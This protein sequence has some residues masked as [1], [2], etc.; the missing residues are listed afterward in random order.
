LT[1]TENVHVAEYGTYV[2]TPDLEN[3]YKLGRAKVNI[4]TDI[5]NEESTDK[6]V[7]V[8]S[9]IVDAE[10]NSVAENVTTEVVSSGATKKFNADVTV[11]N[12]ILWGTENPYLY[13]V[14]TT[15]IIDNKIVDEYETD[16]GIRWFNMTTNDGFFLNGGQ[17]K[18]EGVCM[19]HDQGS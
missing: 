2:T 4:K 8:K 14:A 9:V 11:D 15:V 12:P 5:M 17:M 10:E 13:N 18:L 3:E 1:V 19:H 16:F 7:S 6:E